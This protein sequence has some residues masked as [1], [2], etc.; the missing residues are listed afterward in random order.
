[1]S[2]QHHPHEHDHHDHHDHGDSHDHSDEVSPALQKL[3]YTQIDFPKLRTLNEEEADS[4]LGVIQ[5]S[6]SQRMDLEPSLASDADEQLLIFVPYVIS[7]HSKNRWWPLTSSSFTGSVR[8]HSILLR[9]SP[10]QCAPKTLKLFINKDD[11]DFAAVEDLA[12]TQ[13]LTLS[14]SSDVV[15]YPVRRALFNN[16][17]SLTLFFE[18]NHGDETTRLSYIAFKGE[19]TNL[20]REPVE[21]LYEKAANPKDHALTTKLT[22]GMAGNR[23][24]T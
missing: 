15:E 5:K 19:H 7:T 17:Y 4:G 8:L 6:W 1:M 9:T 21:V 24:G 3:I 23:H 22:Q 13:E 18:D 20:S 10:D 12:T 11:L 16:T 2:H 14:Q